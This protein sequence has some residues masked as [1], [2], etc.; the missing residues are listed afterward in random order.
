MFILMNLLLDYTLYIKNFNSFN[1]LLKMVSIICGTNAEGKVQI[2]L[3]TMP[4]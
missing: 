3:S 2:G 1:A 4:E